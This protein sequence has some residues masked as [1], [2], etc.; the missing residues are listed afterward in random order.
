MRRL[1]G[2]A[3]LLLAAHALV[4]CAQATEI[5]LVVDTDLGVPSELTRVEIDVLNSMAMPTRTSVDLSAAGAPPLPLTL[6]ITSRVRANADVRV[7]VR[8]YLESGEILVRDVSTT[9]SPGS[10]RMLRVV[11]ARRCL[12]TVCSATDTCDETGCRSVT[13]APEELPAWTGSAMRQDGEACEPSEET[14]NLRDDDCDD[15]IDETIERL[16]DAMHCGR[17]GHACTG[18]PCENGFCPGERPV[19]VSAGGAHTCVLREA[20]GVSCFGWNAEGQL[21]SSRLT[22]LSA[23]IEVPVLSGVTELG[24]GG[25]YG[26]VL[27]ARSQLLCVGDGDDGALGRGTVVDARTY[28]AATGSTGFDHLSTGPR[29]ACAID[30]SGSVLCWGFNG[31]GQTGS[32]GEVLAPTPVA[33]LT[34]ASDVGAGLEHSCA[35][36]SGSVYCWGTNAAGQL[37]NAMT[38]GASVAPVLVDGITTATEVALGR[39]FSC[40]LLMDGHVRCWGSNLEGQLGATTAMTS[41][42]ASVEVTGLTDATGISA[43][44]GG[45]HACA[46][47]SGGLVSCWGGNASGQLGDGMTTATT[48]PVELMNVTG[49]VS[50]AAGGLSADGR[51]HTCVVLGSGEVRCA[52]DGTL[53]QTGS[54]TLAAT[55][56]RILPVPGLP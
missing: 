18:G 54:S 10:S 37:G 3:A 29:H 52:G 8:G 16:T 55:S 27:D 50:V 44:A 25:A 19:A 39:D 11:L 6:G 38:V 46:L 15:V 7:E 48:T 5:V 14:C 36:V 20:G 22:L 23:P 34:G 45:T 53:G 32:A 51:G 56:M 13:M 4:G 9:L 26:C 49:A 40:A 43:A 42:V 47:R 2:M 24:A 21:G 31:S 33:T 12:T 35:V 28:A 17:C 1:F 41:S 30:V